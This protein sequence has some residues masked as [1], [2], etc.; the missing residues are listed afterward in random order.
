LTVPAGSQSG[1]IFTLRGQG[2][3]RLNGRGTGD[4]LVELQVRTPTGLCEE[5]KKLLR[6]FDDACK[7]QA[8]EEEE[9]LFSRILRDVLGR[10]KSGKGEKSASAEK[11]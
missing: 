10:K 3:P 11:N 2:V 1:E 6:D 7:R 8:A 9:G 5:Q 4:M